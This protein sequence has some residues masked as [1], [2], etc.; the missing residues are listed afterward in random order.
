MLGLFFFCTASSGYGQLRIGVGMDLFKTDF[1]NIAE[2]NQIGIKAN[3][4]L[5]RNFVLTTG[6][7]MWSSGP[8]SIVL[9]GRFY[10]LNPVFVRFRGLLRNNSDLS[11]GMGYVKSLTRNWK[12]DYT[13]DY[14]FN[15]GEMGIRVG[16]AY[17]F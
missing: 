7:E 15:E 11:L 16:I 5:V 3:Y 17:L 10:P 1:N 2:K 14:Y 6:Y 8:N 9:G 4:F 12:M 13:G